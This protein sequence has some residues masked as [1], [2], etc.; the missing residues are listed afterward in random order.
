MEPTEKT[1]GKV[2]IFIVKFVVTIILYLF[3]SLVLWS[4]NF[5][6][7]TISAQVICLLAIIF[8]WGA[9]LEDPKLDA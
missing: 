5:M 9:N 4:I 7:W 8:V 2:A 1:V 6:L 3:F